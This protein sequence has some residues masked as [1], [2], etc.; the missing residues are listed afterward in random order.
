MATNR[1]ESEH[2]DLYLEI[3][4]FLIKEKE[5]VEKEQIKKEQIE[6]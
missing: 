5:I 2:S 4:K 1:E 6:N 3:E